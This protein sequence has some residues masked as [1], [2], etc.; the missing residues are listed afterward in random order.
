[1][2]LNRRVL[3]ARL[4]ALGGVVGGWTGALS[5]LGSA[6]SAFAQSEPSTTTLPTTASIN[7]LRAPA[8]VERG[9][10][11][12]AL[13]VGSK[14]AAGDKLSTGADA[15]AL[16]RLPEG[17]VVALG[18]NTEFVIDSMKHSSEERSPFV[19][20]LRLAT[21]TM[22]YVTALAQKSNSAN[23]DVSVRTAT[24]TIGV[25]GT[26]FW[27]QC[28]DEG[29]TVCLF[30][31]KVD[32]A[33]ENEPLAVLDQPN[34]FWIAPYRKPAQ[35]V[36]IASPA[37]LASFGGQVSQLEGSGLTKPDG[38]FKLETAAVSRN[39]APLALRQLN[40][41][42]YPA[43]LQG[44]NIVLTHFA[45]AADA[46]AVADKLRRLYGIELNLAKAGG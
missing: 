41:L 8:W 1:M 19:A 45:S 38:A 24:A 16:V 36:G 37:Q 27:A 3:M 20:A 17:S 43:E 30:E 13:R 7:V 26:R 39:D 25:R 4:S 33:R 28:V 2:K 5:S 10:R 14:L 44:A 9:G 11:N 32:I 42:G 18:A 46:Q 40:R 15:R 35:P 29:E 21:G 22:R 12:V 23:R 31:G 6:R 34:A